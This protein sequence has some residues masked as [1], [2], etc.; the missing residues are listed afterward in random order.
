VFIDPQLGRIGMTESEA[1]E[2]NHE[3]RVAN[4]LGQ[5]G[6]KLMHRKNVR[7]VTCGFGYLIGN[8]P[9]DAI[10]CPKRVTKTNDKQP[11]T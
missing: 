8:L 4:R 2:K 5:F 7:R 9:T 3:I 11:A 6:S 1:R 10:V